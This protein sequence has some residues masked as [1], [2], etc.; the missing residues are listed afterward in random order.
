MDASESP[1][2][3]SQRHHHHPR[4]T[5]SAAPHRINP[6]TNTTNAPN[7]PDTTPSITHLRHFATFP[8]R[9]HQHATTHRSVRR[10]SSNDIPGLGARNSL[11]EALSP[12]Q[13]QVL[14]LQQQQQTIATGSPFP[15]LPT[16]I[17]NPAPASPRFNFAAFWNP[18]RFFSAIRP[19]STPPLSLPSPPAS[20]STTSSSSPSSSGTVSR[21]VTSGDREGDSPTPTPS[22]ISKSSSSSSMRSLVAQ[23]ESLSQGHR[24]GPRLSSL[25]VKPVSAT[26]TVTLSL[27]P[28]S[29]PTSSSSGRWYHHQDVSRNRSQQS[30]ASVPAK[31]NALSISKSDSNSSDLDISFGAAAYTLN[32]APPSSSPVITIDTFQI[33]TCCYRSA[34][35]EVSSM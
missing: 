16:T 24:G 22:T 35:T 6:D 27:P 17:V 13:L 20:S 30:L 11:A 28:S 8:N 33:V 26:T 23:G 29:D 5:H 25:S 15:L 3:S 1:P 7:T 32:T 18:Q 34:V 14:Q 31:F 4:N 19:A 12:V 21:M 9:H 2:N 10:V